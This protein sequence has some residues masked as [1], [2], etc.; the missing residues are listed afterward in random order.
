MDVYIQ[1]QPLV[2]LCA[3]IDKVR[4]ESHREFMCVCA[5]APSPDSNPFPA[6]HYRP[7]G[8]SPFSRADMLA[9]RAGCLSLLP[10]RALPPQLCTSSDTLYERGKKKTRHDTPIP[11]N[12]HVLESFHQKEEN[13]L[14]LSS[15]I[16]A[17]SHSTTFFSSQARPVRTMHR[18][19]ERLDELF[20]SHLVARQV[21][22]K[23]ELGRRGGARW[24]RE[25]WA[26]GRCIFMSCWC[27]R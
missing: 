15:F 20:G 21:S 5:S 22:G 3:E 23:A 24:S 14:S 10:G 16:H 18:I 27:T 6:R 25:K 9:R 17:V 13:H 8:P 26:V 1:S 11:H 7:S 4:R 12:A 19:L 2:I